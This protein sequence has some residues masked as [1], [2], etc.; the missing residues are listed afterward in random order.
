MRCHPSSSRVIQKRPLRF[1]GPL[2]GEVGRGGER[3][4]REAARRTPSIP[5]GGWSRGGGGCYPRP[6]GTEAR[7]DVSCR[8][9]TMRGA[10]QG[11]TD[12]QS[13]A[14]FCLAPAHADAA[15]PGSGSGTGARVCSL[16]EGDGRGMG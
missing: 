5:A 16:K 14:H 8:G 4:G 10:L 11:L 2:C 6:V 3:R 1:A 13:H 12:G 7:V 15:P 9:G